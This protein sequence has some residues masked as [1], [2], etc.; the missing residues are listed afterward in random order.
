MP[1]A[2]DLERCTSCGICD[3]I[4]PGD[5]IHINESTGFPVVKYPDECWHCGCCRIDCP[6]GA[7]QIKFPLQMLL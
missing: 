1:P 3:Q 6:E 5:L 4:C 2:I 7:I